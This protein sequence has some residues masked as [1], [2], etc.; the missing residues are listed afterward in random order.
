MFYEKFKNYEKPIYFNYYIDFR[1]RI[2]SSSK[3]SPTSSKIFRQLYNYGIYNKNE[4]EILDEKLEN[5]ITEK[6]INNYTNNI[7]ILNNKNN[8]YNSIII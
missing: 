4:L 7:K 3:I 1:G 6:N 8:K 2:Y 5:S